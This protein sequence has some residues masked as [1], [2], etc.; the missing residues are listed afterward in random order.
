MKNVPISLT[1]PENLVKDL[2]QEFQEASRDRERN[3]EIEL[4]DT[5]SGDGLDEQTK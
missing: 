1:L 3:A 4:W 2:A 5:L